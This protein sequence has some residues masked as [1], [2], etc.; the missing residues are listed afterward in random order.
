MQKK[1]FKMGG[2][3][4]TQYMEDAAGWVVAMTG[5]FD[6]GVFA[7]VAAGPFDKGNGRTEYD[8]EHF[9]VRKD[10][11]T[12]QTR[13]KS[14]LQTVPGHD[15]VYANTHYTVVKATGAFENMTGKFESWGAMEPATGRG[16]LRFSGEIGE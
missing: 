14:V 4:L 10:G 5:D 16:I 7:R 2:T 8:L 9:F 12:I 15:R 11:S 3:A 6:G 13:D 1:T